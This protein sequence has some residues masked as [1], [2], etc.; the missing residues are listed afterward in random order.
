VKTDQQS[1]LLGDEPDAMTI[2]TR[3][4]SAAAAASIVPV[5]VTQRMRIWEALA[6]GPLSDEQLVAVTG[7]SANAV[8]PRRGEL[9]KAGT[10]KAVGEG[11]TAAGKRCV[12]WGRV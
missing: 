10:V 2:T 6:D 7:L 9:V 11:R 5:A 8:R 3:Q 1:W 12:T 4:A